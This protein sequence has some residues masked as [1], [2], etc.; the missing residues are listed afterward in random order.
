MD[1]IRWVMDNLRYS[2]E[3]ACRLVADEYS[4]S[5]GQG[6][7]P[8]TCGGGGGSMCSCSSCTASVLSQVADGHTCRDRI[9]WV[10]NNLGYS[11]DDA[12]R[13]AADEYPSICGQG[14]DP[15]AC[16]GGEMCIC[17]SC[18]A[19]VLDNIADGHSCR[20]RI[21]WVANNLNMSERQA[22]AKV[23]DE[24]PSICGQGCDPDKCA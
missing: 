16:A 24:Y 22:C 13:L 7:D 23:A 18:T 17:A 19:S 1:R 14:C 11:Q 4:S 9:D 21:N 6:C 20:D 12:C 2:E 15:D 5:C 8:D 10:V 3:N